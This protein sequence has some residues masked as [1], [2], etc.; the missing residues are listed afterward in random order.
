MKEV[1]NNF[2]TDIRTYGRQLDYE[3]K[4]DD[5]FIDN[6]KVNY[7]KP[8][9]NTK[10]FKTVMHKLE[11]DLKDSLVNNTKINIKTGVK[12]NDDYEYVEYNT[13]RA[14]KCERQE[15]TNSYIITAYD[16]MI[17][18]MIDYDLNLSQK[19]TVREYLIVICERLGWNTEHIPNTFINSA[20]LIDPNL[21][22]GIKYTFRDALD[23]IATISC[24]FMYFKGED[25]YLAYPTNTNENID[26][27]YLD[28]DGIT[29]GEKYIINSLVFSR[30]EGSDN[31]YRKDDASIAINGL[32]EFRISDNQLLSTNERDNFID[33]MFNY[34]K[35]FEFYVFDV[36]SKGILFLEVCDM[37]NYVLGE[38][39]YPTILL[40]DETTFEDGLTEDLYTDQPEE[41]ETEYKYADETDRRINQTYLIVDKQNQVIESVISNVDE[42][43]TKISRVQQTVDS[44]NSKIS[45]IAD[46]TTSQETQRG[47]L[48]FERIN[49]SEPVHIEIRPIG[50]N[51]SYLYP[52]ETL[53]PSET[54]FITIR[55]LRFTNTDTNEVFDYELPDDLLFYDNDNYDEFIWDYD[56]QTIYINKKCKYNSNTGEVELLSEPVTN[57]Y[58]FEHIY[59]T[60]GNY[61][62]QVLKYDDTPYICYFMAR[63]MTQN[64]YTTQW[65][66]KA[67]LNSE[68]NQTAEEISANV[69]KKLTNY[70][71]ST[72]MNSAISMKANEIATSVSET[73]ATKTALNTAK[74]EIKQTTD[75]ISETVSNNNTKAS[76]VA[77]INDKTSSVKIEADAI[78]I[79]GTV[80]ANGNFKVDTEGNL[81]AKN[82][83]FTGTVT[84]SDIRGSTVGFYE[85]SNN[86][87]K[88]TKNGIEVMN[89]DESKLANVGVDFKDGTGNYLVLK[90]GT[91]FS[92]GS[93]FDSPLSLYQK[94]F[95]KL[96]DVL[97][98]DGLQ[99]MVFNENWGQSAN[100]LTFS[101]LTGNFGITCWSSDRNLKK[102][103]NNSSVD[104]LDIISKIKH[105]EFRWKS[106]GIKNN[107]GYIAQELE[108]LNEEFVL[109][110]KQDDGTYRYQ[111][112]EIA[113]IPYI[114]KAFQE[115]VEKTD[116]RIDKLE[117]EIKILKEER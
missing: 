68:L 45:D 62:I 72:E 111:V 24:S 73:Y 112:N 36:K 94:K 39:T 11:I 66:T 31:I 10:L 50:E 113:L 76:I 82:G 71:T 116:A 81:E 8:S 12:L 102:E 115:Y 6:D 5:E 88:F 59:L 16:K 41:S 30:A 20:K 25:F 61:T 56:S 13:Y 57:E 51:I 105:R 64:L 47:S 3:I 37:F 96:W 60:D 83:K 95:N 48:T 69:N 33:E 38:K 35:T 93:F 77:K 7:I 106:N 104:A 74:S 114:T 110:I 89:S 17:E 109:K 117:Q 98:V 29:I 86:Y 87:V 70:S 101:T 90:T 85:D 103:I 40:N 19:I 53:Y 107:C 21:H 67:E 46:I 1:T 63:L 97:L 44:L 15:D 49:Q 65:A 52:F 79:N 4:L 55:T 54:L 27:S 26:D 43:N 108:E 2:K 42:Q 18:S 9:F 92:D 91:I 99:R 22:E 84:G 80:S 32:H 23:E 100:T 14:K 28:E 75:S 58:T 78:D 34:L